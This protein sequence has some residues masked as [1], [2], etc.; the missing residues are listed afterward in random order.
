MKHYIILKQR[1]RAALFHTCFFE[2][3]YTLL[4]VENK[5]YREKH[6]KKKKPKMV[7]R[8]REGKTKVKKKKKFPHGLV[9]D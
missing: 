3:V 8:E 4:I 1:E 6:K 2:L 5:N 7:N 9:K